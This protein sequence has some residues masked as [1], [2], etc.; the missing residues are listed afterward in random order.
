MEELGI[1]RPS[2]YAATITTV[3]KRGYV[4]KENRD[5]EEKKVQNNLLTNFEV[6]ELEKN[7]LVGTEKQKLF[8]TDIGIVV[9]DFLIEHFSNVMQY[10]FTASVENEFDEIAE[11]KSME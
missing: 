8:P 10:S 9:T 5:G 2:T 6:K 1:G 4:E 7:V 3:Q 11:G